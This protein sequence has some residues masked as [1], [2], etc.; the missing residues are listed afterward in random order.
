MFG[1]CLQV[2]IDTKYKD[3][4]CGLCGNFDGDADDLR[5]NG[6]ILFNIME[7]KCTVD[8]N[9]E[10]KLTFK[11]KFQIDITRLYGFVL[12]QNKYIATCFSNAFSVFTE[13]ELF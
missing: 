1:L 7:G 5:I 3:Q 6:K 9:T 13:T 4:L 12:R 11:N 8:F 10:K 2:E